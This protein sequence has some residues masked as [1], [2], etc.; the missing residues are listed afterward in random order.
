MS[1]I[2]ADLCANHTG[3]VEIA[4]SMIKCLGDV[5]VDYAKVQSINHHNLVQ[6]PGVTDIEHYYNK[7][8]YKEVE[9]SNEDHF[10]IKKACDDN[11]VKMLC[12]CFN[13]DRIPFLKELKLDVVKVASPDLTSYKMIDALLSCHKRVIVSTAGCT[14]GELNNSFN[15]YGSNV[16]FMYCN[17]YYPTPLDKVSMAVLI[18]QFKGKVNFGYSDHTMGTEASKYA[19][20]LGAEYVEKHFTLNRNLPGRDQFMST[21]IDEFKELVEWQKV[22]VEMTGI[23]DIDVGENEKQYREKF[24]GRWGNNN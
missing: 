22:V 15:R 5:G 21:T 16:T 7:L 12:T 19:I 1:Y 4:K 9:L 11:N 8:Y 20:C 24:I 3:N 10:E 18:N 17:P 6:K 23:N 2:I 14:Q 13:I